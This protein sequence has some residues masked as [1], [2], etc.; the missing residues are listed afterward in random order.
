MTLNIKIT[1]DEEFAKGK[2]IRDIDTLK[3]FTTQ[4]QNIKEMG[5]DF[6]GIWK[7]GTNTLNLIMAIANKFDCEFVDNGEYIIPILKDGK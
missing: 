5:L 7:E 2:K 6:L 1:K 4:Y 3:E